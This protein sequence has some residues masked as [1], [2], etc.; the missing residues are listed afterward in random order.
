MSYIV[1]NRLGGLHTG[2]A[3]Y[4]YFPTSQRPAGKYGVILLHG[5]GVPDEWDIGTAWESARLAGT[6]ANAGIPCVAGYMGGDT[7]GNDTSQTRMTEALAYLAA[8]TGASSTKAHVIGVSMGGAVG[9][10]W[11]A[12]N[13][14][15]AATYTGLIPLLDPVSAYNTNY[16]GFRATIGTAWGVTYPTALPAGASIA[17]AVSSMSGVVPSKVFY[18]SSDAVIDPARQT[19]AGA[20]MGATVTNVG[21]NG[22]SELSIADAATAM[23]GWADLVTWLLANGA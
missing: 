14:S 20:T 11:A 15:K 3:D 1:K 21:T 19:A 8:Q 13:T 18:S 9:A 16:G 2:E 17:T 6:L 10:R 5:A 23:H 7:F 4:I 12:A 22:H